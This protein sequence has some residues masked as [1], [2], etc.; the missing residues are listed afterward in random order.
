MEV[1]AGLL[2]GGAAGMENRSAFL[3][4]KAGKLQFLECTRRHGGNLRPVPN[5]FG[6]QTTR[7]TNFSISGVM[8][9]LKREQFE[10]KGIKT[11]EGRVTRVPIR[12]LQFGV[13]DSCNS[14]L[15]R[16]GPAPAR[17]EV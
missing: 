13:R 15:R 11:S 6:R 5:G 4:R 10:G 3:R 1:A 8:F 2:R 9:V 16:N 14:S 12:T 7:L 17:R